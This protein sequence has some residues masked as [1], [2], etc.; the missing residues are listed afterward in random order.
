MVS[1]D[2]DQQFAELA[3]VV[4]A[5]APPDSRNGTSCPTFGSRAGRRRHAPVNAPGSGGVPTACLEGR[6]RGGTAGSAD[7]RRH[8]ANSGFYEVKRPVHSCSVG[9]SVQLPKLKPVAP[10][11]SSVNSAP[12][13]RGRPSRGFAVGLT[14]IEVDDL[15]VIRSPVTAGARVDPL[16]PGCSRFRDRT[17]W[18][19]WL[20]WS[21]ALNRTDAFE[22]HSFRF[23]GL[24]DSRLLAEVRRTPASGPDPSPAF[25]SRR[26]RAS[27]D[28]TPVL[29]LTARDTISDRVTGGRTPAARAPRQLELVTAM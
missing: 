16:L 15:I 5:L 25:I 2:C 26:L 28:H 27:G 12:V 17:T 23:Q 22:S 11:P 6:A 1:A 29:M 8:G 18:S 14:R 20:T 19:T 7:H 21:F 3:V 9:R 10:S 13:L 4:W 24:C